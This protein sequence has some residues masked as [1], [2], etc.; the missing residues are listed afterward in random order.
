MTKK[1]QQEIEEWKGKYFRALADY[2]NLEK[3]VK[4]QEKELVKYASEKIIH[5]LL[6]VL[7]TFEQAEEHLKDPGL[8]LGVKSFWE[9]L[10]KHGVVKIEALGKKFNPHEMECVEVVESEKEDDVIEE[11]R[12][13]YKLEDKVIRVAQVKVG[14]KIENKSKIQNPKSETNLNY[15]NTNDQNR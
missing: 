14:K 4:V 13:G 10:V 8:T 7:D 5:E 12:A 1:L 2:Q 9:V 6:A 15:Q 11:V 3:R